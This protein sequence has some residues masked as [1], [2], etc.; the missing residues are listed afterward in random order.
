MYTE[1]HVELASNNNSGDIGLAI[2]I[3]DETQYSTR[4]ACKPNVCFIIVMGVER[5]AGVCCLACACL[6][7]ERNIE[8]ISSK[9]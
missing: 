2:S 4:H 6:S 7:S 5:R 9:E 1:V 3:T 8:T